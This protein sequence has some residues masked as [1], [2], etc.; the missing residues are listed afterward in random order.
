MI[1]FLLY[2]HLDNNSEAVLMLISFCKLVFGIFVNDSVDDVILR[3][4]S[5]ADLQKIL[6]KVSELGHK[7]QM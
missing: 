2:F 4:K 5:Q 6:D 1:F 7:L 3:A